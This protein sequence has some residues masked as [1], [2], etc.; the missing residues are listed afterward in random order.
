[1]EHAAQDG[2]LSHEIALDLVNGMAAAQGPL[3]ETIGNNRKQQEILISTA[4][5]DLYV[6]HVACFIW[7]T[8][9]CM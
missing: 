5:I 7:C 2:L 4:Y 6:S 8:Y 1:M 3:Q 9:A